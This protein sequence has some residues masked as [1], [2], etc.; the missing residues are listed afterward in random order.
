MAK[1]AMELL[2]L[3]SALGVLGLLLAL[4]RRERRRTRRGLIALALVW[5]VYL[6]MLVTVSLTQ[7]GRVAAPGVS[8]CFDQ[9]CFS[10]AGV[11][12]VAGFSA[13]GLERER[14]VRVAVRIVNRD[15]LRAER[16]S[17]LRSYLVD[18]AGQRW[19]EI[20]GLSGVR[21]SV[22]VSAGGSTVSEPVFTVP[23]DAT[24][25]GLVL[26]HGRFASRLLIIGDPESWLH[27]PEVMLL[28]PPSTAAS[29][30]EP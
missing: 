23:R 15:H 6:L 9:M 21:S 8:Q 28:P 25:L 20:M 22:L 12:E 19:S 13:R 24:G 27:R 29:F 11:E 3:W 1:L 4:V 16:E 26:H 7:P 10:V 17:G 5:G 30:S 2:V 18:R 14:L